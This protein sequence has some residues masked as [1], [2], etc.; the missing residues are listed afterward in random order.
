M[1]DF[2][3]V[4]S[5]IH[6]WAGLLHLARGGAETRRSP[7][8]KRQFRIT[9]RMPRV[10]GLPNSLGGRVEWRG[11][12]SPPRSPRT[13]RESLN[14]SGSQYP[15]VRHIEAASARRALAWS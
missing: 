5:R 14:S 11:G 2:P 9:A 7:G 13:G 3:F 10:Q 6:L 1:H 12:V 8:A 15:V 4:D